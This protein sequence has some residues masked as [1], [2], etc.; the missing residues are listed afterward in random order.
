VA[1]LA[2]GTSGPTRV[3]SSRSRAW[4]AQ[5]LG[6]LGEFA[7]GR[8][9]GEEARRL[10][11]GDGHWDDAPFAVHARLGS[12][13]LAQGDLDAAIRVFEEGLALG[14]TSGNRAP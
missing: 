5:V 11:R 2:R 4:L 14:R 3:A 12:R 6:L 7:E 10:A 9:H 1:A 8:R 13:S